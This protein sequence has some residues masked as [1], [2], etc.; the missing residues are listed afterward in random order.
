MWMVAVVAIFLALMLPAVSGA[1]GSGSTTTAI[2]DLF[3]PI[4]Q[5]IGILFVAVCA[6]AFLNWWSGGGF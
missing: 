5:V 6:G 3:D 1:G 2:S 4:G